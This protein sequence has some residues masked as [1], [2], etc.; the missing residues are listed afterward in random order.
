MQIYDDDGY[1]KWS[2]SQQRQVKSICAWRW[3]LQK[4]EDKKGD[5]SMS[6]AVG[7]TVHKVN[8][9]ALN[10]R[11][12]IHELPDEETVNKWSDDWFYYYIEKDGKRMLSH[13]KEYF[14]SHKECIDAYAEVA[15]M[16]SRKCIEK[17]TPN[18]NPLII[19]GVPA[20]EQSWSFKIEEF[21]I[22]MRGRYD[23]IEIGNMVS[24]LKIKQ[25]R[26]LFAK[27]KD[28]G[29][30][31]VSS[32]EKD[33]QFIIYSASKY[34]ET[35]GVFPKVKGHFILNK[36]NKND[37]FHGIYDPVDTVHNNSHMVTLKNI[38]RGVRPLIEAAIKNPDI[39]TPCSEYSTN[40]FCSENQ[41][42]YWDMCD[43]HY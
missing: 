22:K 9:L 33:E 35:G 24:D 30:N 10:V 42:D 2:A 5:C 3:V 21:K 40:M 26:P 27:P 36:N 31:R 12:Q 18:I 19:D 14:K 32:I 34:T 13:E 38:L 29:A 39:M 11:H 17:C 1:L 43:K 37:G 7:S 41:C 15:R 25:G 28:Y 8:E 16:L 23:V 6:M 4:L 20:I